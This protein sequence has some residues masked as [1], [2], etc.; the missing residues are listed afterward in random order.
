MMK[1]LILLFLICITTVFA[2][3]GFVLMETS[4]SGKELTKA[5]SDAVAKAGFVPA[6]ERDLNVAFTKQ[7]EQSDFELYYNLTVFDAKTL[8]SVLP[9]N[10]KLAGFV[11]YTVLIYQKKGDKKSFV[12][13]VK[14]EAVSLATGVKDKKTLGALKASEQKLEK[15]LKSTLKD[16]KDTKLSYKSTPKEDKELFFEAAIKLKASDS[17]VA[18]KEALQKEFESTVEVEGFKISNITDL[19]TELEKVKAD[20]SK[21]EF[22][23]TYSICKLKVIYN[24]SKERPEAGVF[25]PCSIYFYKLKSENVIHVGFPPTKNWVVHTNIA[26]SEYVK[27]MQEAENIVKNMLKEAAE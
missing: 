12:G 16:A 14:T 7:F 24:A 3:D 27:I 20:M 9:S 11:P 23:E 4:K 2:A 10:P 6:D 8:G 19:K 1:K 15:A 22:F 18:K 25:A 5:V 26:N 17:A 13:F 21:Y